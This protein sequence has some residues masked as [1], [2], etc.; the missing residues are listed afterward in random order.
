MVGPLP[1]NSPEFAPCRK[2]R[3]GL[4]T[5]VPRRRLAWPAYRNSVTIAR[6]MARRQPTRAASA[7]PLARLLRKKTSPTMS[8]TMPTKSIAY[9]FPQ[10]VRRSTNA[11]AAAAAQSDRRFSFTEFSSL[12]PGRVGLGA[13]RHPGWRPPPW[14]EFDSPCMLGPATPSVTCCIC[15]V[16]GPEVLLPPRNN[17][18][19]TIRGSSARRAPNSSTSHSADSG[20]ASVKRCSPRSLT[21]WRWGW[22]IPMTA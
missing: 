8:P 10:A 2:D 15:D 19:G 16:L 12:R 3:P 9:A 17:G 13:D 22:G 11:T 18:D 6:A 4:S 7:P 1:P 21:R 20:V 14:A 5:L